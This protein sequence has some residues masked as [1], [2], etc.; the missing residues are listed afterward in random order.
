ME[1]SRADLDGLIKE[2]KLPFFAYYSVKE[3]A[4]EKSQNQ[5]NQQTKP[6]TEDIVFL[7]KIFDA[8]CFFTKCF[9]QKLQNYLLHHRPSYVPTDT[10]PLTVAKPP[11]GTSDANNFIFNDIVAI[12]YNYKGYSLL[13]CKKLF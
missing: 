5:L 12:P 9:S 7:Y 6:D 1:A 11:P 10:P 13:I 3:T 8:K 4:P 2:N